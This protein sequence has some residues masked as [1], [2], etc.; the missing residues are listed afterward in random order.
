MLQ[1]NSHGVRKTRQKS[2]T[3]FILNILY[4][5]SSVKDIIC[6][7]RTLG[8]LSL[9]DDDTAT[10]SQQESCSYQSLTRASLYFSSL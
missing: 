4:F 9:N 2:I 7:K 3:I 10:N 8:T 1:T 5:F 6:L